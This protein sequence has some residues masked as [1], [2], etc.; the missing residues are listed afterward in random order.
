MKVTVK[1]TH[2]ELKFPKLMI[3][4]EIILLA[5]SY[6]ENM[7]TYRGYVVKDSQNVPDYT[8]GEY[9]DDWTEQFEDFNGEVIMSNK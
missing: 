9:A 2:Q 4:Q 8:V 6:D 7:N 3:H 5:I 1:N